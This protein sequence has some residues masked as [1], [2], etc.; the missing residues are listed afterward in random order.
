MIQALHSVIG[1]II[2]SIVGIFA[3]YFALIVVLQDLAKSRRRKLIS[4][5]ILANGPIPNKPEVK[6]EISPQEDPI[7]DARLV[8]IQIQNTGNIVVRPKDYDVPIT[9]EFGEKVISSN[10]IQ[11]T[12]PAKRAKGNTA[13]LT[14]PD[15]QSVS[16]DK[17]QLKPN[18]AIIM[19][20]TVDGPA[21]QRIKV[22][23]Q[24]ADG[25]I[26]EQKGAVLTRN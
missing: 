12:V 23:G 14:R 10:I 26:Y 11:N 18:E 24:I 9:F 17:L 2:I 13:Q 6:T 7:T 19:S 20:A 3:C 15:E 21:G 1:T 5:R 25:R 16:L 22:K 8:I 4:Y